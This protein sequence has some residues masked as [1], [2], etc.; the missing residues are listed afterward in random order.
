MRECLR[1]FFLANPE[2]ELTIDDI[3]TKWGCSKRAAQEAV[4]V[5][6]K[7][8]ECLTVTTVRAGKRH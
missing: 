3:M 2:E 5:L 4:S 8:G 1:L 6:A 7:S